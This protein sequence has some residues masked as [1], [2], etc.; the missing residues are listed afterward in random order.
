MAH[1][2]NSFQKFYLNGHD[3]IRRKNILVPAGNYSGGA[4]VVSLASALETEGAAKIC[5][6]QIVKG[7][8]AGSLHV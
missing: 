1:E 8:R 6:L 2:N 5:R 7:A 4:V 3:S